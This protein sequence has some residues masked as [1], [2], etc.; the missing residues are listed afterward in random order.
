[1]TDIMTIIK[2]ERKGKHLNTLEKYHV[3]KAN[4]EGPIMNDMHNETQNPIFE[5][6]QDTNR[7][8]R[9]TV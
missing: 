7:G 8:H 1:M 5:I 2:I 3:Y 9:D 6:L 4:K